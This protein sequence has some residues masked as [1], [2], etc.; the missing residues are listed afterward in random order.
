MVHHHREDG[1]NGSGVVVVLLQTVLLCVKK[2]RQTH[3]R[4]SF[5]GCL[6]RALAA[7]FSHC[8][9]Q[10]HVMKFRNRCPTSANRKE[11]STYRHDETAARAESRQRLKTCYDFKI[12]GDPSATGLVDYRQFPRLRPRARPSGAR[13]WPQTCRH[14]PQSRAACRSGG[15][16]RRSG[17]HCR[18]RRH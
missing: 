7:Q 12:Q 17:S 9:R 18:T 4:S 6:I 15:T 2:N 5:L 10:D 13:R 16:L 1:G 8:D 14:G 11:S 3:L